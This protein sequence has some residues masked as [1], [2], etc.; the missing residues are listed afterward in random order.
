MT[1]L[2]IH[3]PIFFFGVVFADIENLKDQK[4]PLDHIRA[5]HWGWKIVVNSILIILFFSL[6]SY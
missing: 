2:I 1:D 4:K 3:T 5:L 6:G